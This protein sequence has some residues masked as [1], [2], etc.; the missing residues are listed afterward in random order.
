MKSTAYIDTPVLSKPSKAAVKAQVKREKEY[1]IRKLDI[2]SIV[3]FE[4]SSHWVG[5]LAFAG[6]AYFVMDN[7]GTLIIG[8]IKSL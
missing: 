3:W 8:L 5:L 2:G 4:V 7:F 6:V 1:D